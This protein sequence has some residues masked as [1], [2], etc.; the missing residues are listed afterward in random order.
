M[1]MWYLK[2]KRENRRISCNSRAQ[3][4]SDFYYQWRDDDGSIPWTI[5]WEG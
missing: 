4:I 5:E 2:H 3:A 1:T